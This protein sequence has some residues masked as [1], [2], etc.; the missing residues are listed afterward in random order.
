VT[1]LLAPDLCVIGGGSGRPFRRR[2]RRADVRVRGS[3]RGQPH[4]R[5]LVLRFPFV[6]IDRA[7][8]ERETEG[9]AKVIVARG[10]P[11]G[12]G[13]VGPG[14]GVLIGFWS[15]ALA[16]EVKLSAIAGM[17]APYPTLGEISRRAAGQHYAARLFGNPRVR[18]LVRLVQRWLP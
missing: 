1:R 3:G 10:R 18:K 13:V 2:R 4:G 8:A 9:L 7:R 16:G 11:V 6:G 12:A 15:L 5:R 14:V 17:V